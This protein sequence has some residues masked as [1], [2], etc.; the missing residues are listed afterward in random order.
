[1]TD[2]TQAPEDTITNAVVKK[3]RNR[4]DLAN[5][6]A[7]NTEPGD[8]SRYL[9]Y[10]LASWDLPPIDISDPKQVESRIHAYFAYCVEN[11]RKPQLVGMANWLGVSRDT[12]NSWKR[13]EY[14]TETH[15]DLIKKA[16]GL[17]EEMWVDY[18]QNGKVNPASGIFLG[19]NFFNYRDQTDVV[20]TPN[21]PLDTL[22]TDQARRK[23]A[24]SLPEST[25]D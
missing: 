4:P 3:R 19:K 9:R 10:A 1:M 21:N 6:G 14:R 12:L 13:G 5:F 11:D 23:Y 25:T 8:N 15:S 17:L 22:D 7:E 2:K 24:E 20:V 18:M 16:I